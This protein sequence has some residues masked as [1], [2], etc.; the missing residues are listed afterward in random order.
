MKLKL[1]DVIIIVLG[2]AA[3]IA[4]ITII[5]AGSE[6]GTRVIIRDRNDSYTYPLGKDREIRLEGPVGQTHITIKDDH[7]YVADSDCR[8]KLCINKGSIAQTNQWIA[9]LPNEIFVS[10]EGDKA[11]D[12]F[13]ISSH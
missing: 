4:S 9:C 1:F 5:Y 13:D 10:I 8:N 2:V 3:L 12:K 11:D 6:A 7:V